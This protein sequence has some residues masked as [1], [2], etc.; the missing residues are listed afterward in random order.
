MKRSMFGRKKRP[1]ITS[2][3]NFEHRV[4]TNFNRE[5]GRYEGL[6]VQWTSIVSNRPRPTPF[7]DS[8]AITPVHF[9]DR[10]VRGSQRS[11]GDGGKSKRTDISRSNSLREEKPAQ[12]TPMAPNLGKITENE[13]E[14]SLNNDRFET[15]KV[16]KAIKRASGSSGSYTVSSSAAR[17][18]FQKTRS[19]KSVQN[20][21]KSSPSITSSQ[22]RSEKSSVRHRTEVRHQM[23]PQS[24]S[25]GD[26]NKH[27]VTKRQLPNTDNLTSSFVMNQNANYQ[28]RIKLNGSA[29]SADG[30]AAVAQN[31]SNQNNV[32][33]PTSASALL[34]PPTQQ[35]QQQPKKSSKS[36]EKAISHEEFK[37]ALQ[38]VVCAGDPTAHLRMIKKIGEGST[39]HVYAAIE[40]QSKQMVAVKKMNLRKQQ[41]RELLF[42]EVVIMKDYN[43]ENIVEMYSSFIVADELWVVMEY[44]VGGS[45]TDIVTRT[46]LKMKEYQIATVCKSVLRALVYLHEKGVIHRDIKSDCILLDD[47]GRIKLSDFGFCAQINTEINKRKSLV[48][49]PY[50]MAPELISREPYGTAVDIWSLGIMVIEMIDGEPPHFNETPREAMMRTKKSKTPPGV[51]QANKISASLSGF[52]DR[53]LVLRAEDR[54]TASE[55]LRHPFIKLARDSPCLLP[56]ISA[57]QAQLFRRSNT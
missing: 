11:R 28:S 22:D 4:H 57:K 38:Q 47:E 8:S 32:A 33:T 3:Y 46:G 40:K 26:L 24:K 39:A 45:L 7:V 16:E 23:P 6:P 34:T 15:E 54:A 12:G 52:L 21:S 13:H 25:S 44:L 56:L 48:G 18:T 20:Q 29:V 27:S 53:M 5:E 43:H 10:I 41:R 49:T 19:S 35:Q 37:A 17:I 1:E 2:P 42:N 31:N 9:E 36:K 55:L 30:A 51:K 50:W 14:Q